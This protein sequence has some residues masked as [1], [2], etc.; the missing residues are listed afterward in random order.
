MPCTV[1]STTGR[2][3][4][5][6]VRP[7]VIALV[8]AAASTP[9]GWSQ[10]VGGAATSIGVR[11]HGDERSVD[12]AEEL[13]R[14]LRANRGLAGSVQR[15]P[16]TFAA[17]LARVRELARNAGGAA[18]L[19]P[20]LKALPDNEPFT[21]RLLAVREFAQGRI[22]AAALLLLAAYEKDPGSPDALADLAGVFAGL[23]YANEALAFLD[24]L[25]ARN[26]VPAPPMDIAG[27]D[28]LAY[29]RAYSLV[30]LGDTAAAKPLLA[31][32]VARQPLLAE[33]ARLLA[34]ISE[35]PQEQRKYFLLGVWRHRGPLMVGAG[36]DSTKDEP[37]PLSVGDTV[38]VDLRSL[39]D[40]SKGERGRLPD[41]T[42]AR[43]ALQANGLVPV[44]E[45]AQVAT[46]SELRALVEQG[47]APGGV[48]L[49]LK[50]AAGVETWGNRMASVLRSLFLRDRKLRDLERARRSAYQDATKAL[51]DLGEERDRLESEA[52]DRYA[53]EIV[54]KKLPSPTFAQMGEVVR[55][56]RDATLSR[57]RGAMERQEKAERDWFAEWHL[58]ATSLAAQV[59]D[60]GY[61]EYFRLFVEAERVR[62]YRR[63][64]NI[65]AAHARAG[66]HPYITKEPGEPLPKL[67]SQDMGKCD[68]DESMSFTTEHDIPGGKALPFSVGVEL[69]CEGMSAELGID[70]RIPGI[71][72]STELGVDTKGDFTV[73]VGPKAEADVMAL[74]GS[75][76]GGAY[77]TGN[78]NGIKDA[79]VKYEVK[80][81]VK[82]GIVSASQK[83]AEGKVSFLPAV[84]G[85]DG[86]L[87]PLMV[88]GRR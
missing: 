48:K 38:A 15:Q 37:D 54:A 10:T 22:T 50:N 14:L 27:A 44:L 11:S 84:A 79:G 51:H 52:L 26:A 12:V 46:E 29:L 80:T 9:V 30:R 23:G 62:N 41:I 73:F 85:A 7:L 75:A 39:L 58:L 56:F 31:G 78:R 69:T 18:A 64:L 24:E 74:S 32:V 63:L 4:T 88:N 8:L 1:L 59:G 45:A 49:K 57:A 5:S 53:R 6:R 43:S 68:G 60:P 83:V 70:T 35:D 61:T 71:N 16:M 19:A 72:V 17:A 66:V 47:R 42:Y 82:A 20:A 21:L 55:P 34:V 87:T 33:A 3:A 25:R 67:Q 36:V 76:K 40:L 65:A 86:G 81:S 13:Q 2:F 77:L 28:S